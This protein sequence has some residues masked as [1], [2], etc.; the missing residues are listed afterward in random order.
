MSELCEPAEV[1]GASATNRGLES[2]SLFNPNGP[3]DGPVAYEI[4]FLVSESQVAEIA[5]RVRGHL[6][7]DAYAEPAMGNAYLTTS[8][9]SDTPAFD[10]YYR[11]DG[12]DRDKLRGRRYGTTGPVFVE[13]KT[14][15]GDKVRKHRAA[16]HANE[17]AELLAPETRGEWAGDWFHAELLAKALRP[18]CR[19]TYERVAYLG[20]V[21]GGTVRLT[22][23][24]N[25]RGALCGDWNLTPVPRGAPLLEQVIAEFKFRTAM[26][27]LFKG[28]VAD[29][30]LT[31]T[32]VSKYRTFVRRTGLVAERG[33]EDA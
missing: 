8:V 19:V 15:R 12:Y 23:D 11:T 4:K 13:R 31:P 27:A 20:T 3:D 26:P 18:V 32:P 1:S 6:A 17:L 7:L 2:P 25:V 33:A 22:F 21:E 24:R 9:Y 14:K 28:I 30:A 10:V 29:L 16:V 5:A